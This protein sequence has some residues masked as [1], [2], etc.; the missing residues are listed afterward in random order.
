[1]QLH[2]TDASSLGSS[3]RRVCCLGEWPTTAA[4]A[5]PSKVA[6][7]ESHLLGGF[8]VKK[9]RAWKRG[10]GERTVPN[11]NKL[12]VD[13][14]TVVWVSGLSEIFVCNVCRIHA[15][16][17]PQFVRKKWAKKDFDSESEINN[18]FRGFSK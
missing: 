16:Y 15:S 10:I 1:M 18:D 3:E 9:E 11:Q 5:V 13:N 12:S 2:A 8:V 17:S 7:H 6:L 4:A 14:V